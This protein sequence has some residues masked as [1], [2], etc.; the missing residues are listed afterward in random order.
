MGKPQPIRVGDKFKSPTCDVIWEVIE[1]RPGG[2][3]ELFDRVR[4]RFCNTYHR[5]V[6]NWERVIVEKCF[7]CDVPLSKNEKEFCRLHLETGPKQRISRQRRRK[8]SVYE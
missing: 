6:K 4:T 3:V 2:H 5:I 1:T 8:V 7:E